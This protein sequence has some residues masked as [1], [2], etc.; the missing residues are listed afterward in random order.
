MTRVETIF[1][2]DR[3][4]LR[5]V[6]LRDGLQLVRQFPNTLAKQD[7]LNREY[8]A[9][10]RVFE[11]GSFLPVNRFPQF[12]DVRDL[13]ATTKTLPGAFAAALTLNERGVRDALDTAVDEIV[14]VISATEA[15]SQA[16]ARRS[17]KEAIDMLKRI[18]AMRDA[19]GPSA[20]IV[21]A[22]IA[23]AFGCSLEGDVDPTSVL[24]LV[25]RCA[26][27]GVDVVALA[28]TVGYATPKAVASLVTGTRS[29]V[30]GMPISVHL[31]DT[32]GMAVANAVAA[33][34]EGVRILDGSLGGLGGCPFA[35]GAT[36][37]IVYE[38]MVFLCESLGFDTGIDIQ[39]L[40]QVRDVLTRHMPDEALFGGM[41]RAGL[42]D[43][44]HWRNRSVAL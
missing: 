13:I 5:E 42:P 10:V 31:H 4:T 18:V 38:D 8:A 26:M 17:R 9:G 43:M 41:A 6:G 33:L 15:H 24:H 27:S 19:A 2:S 40:V 44:Q 32:R 14:F 28:D 21:T 22:G 12:V 34:D 3:V 36:G 25:E 20:P 30:G 7:W 23:M 16:N 39:R 29:I 11:V 1:P 35:P 37:N